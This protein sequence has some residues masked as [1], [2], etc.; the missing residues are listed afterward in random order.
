MTRL[1]NDTAT[2]QAH[3]ATVATPGAAPGHHHTF[4]AGLTA[5]EV[6]VLALLATG[7]TNKEIAAALVV[8]PGTVAQHLVTIYTKVGARRRTDAATFALQHG[9]A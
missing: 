8:S 3:L 1:V 4:P 5:R 7:A 6:E 9:L 2:L